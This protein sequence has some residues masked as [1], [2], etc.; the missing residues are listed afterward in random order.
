VANHNCK[1]YTLDDGTVTDA[2]EV[3]KRVGITTKNARS[4][5]SIHTDPIKVFKPKL[6]R[7]KENMDS[8]KMRK[9]MKRGMFDEMLV[10]AMKSI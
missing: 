6:N 2:K 4:R 3:A 10:L 5:L 8:Y 7:N 1:K 9:I